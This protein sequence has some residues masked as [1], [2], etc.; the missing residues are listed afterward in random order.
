M[1]EQFRP[2]PE[3]VHKPKAPDPA[4]GPLGTSPLGSEQPQAGGSTSPERQALTSV[5][6]VLERS[7]KLEARNAEGQ[8]GH[9]EY[10]REVGE[11]G[12]LE[13]EL[14]EKGTARDRLIL[15]LYDNIT[16]QPGGSWTLPF[17]IEDPSPEELKK[18]R[19]KVEPMSETEIAEELRKQKE[20]NKRKAEELRKRRGSPPPGIIRY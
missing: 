19:S 17:E 8:I 12:R 3:S 9:E 2:T 20:E 6:D 4:A 16:I 11:V 14:M 5:W 18:F 13:E 10:D 15:E 7:V 1:S